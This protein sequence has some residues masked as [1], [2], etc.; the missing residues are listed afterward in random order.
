MMAKQFRIGH[1][2][3]TWG[4]R[5]D[6]LEGAVRD[7]AELGYQGFET[8]GETIVDYNRQDP[9]GFGALLKKYGIPLASIY[10]PVW[11]RE[12]EQAQESIEQVVSWSQLARDLGASTVV[13]Q[14]GKRQPQPYKNYPFLVG[15]FDEIGRRLADMG[16][17]T[18]VHP[19]T[20][21]L[22]ETR[23]EIDAVLSAVDP[24]FVGF[25]PDTGQIVKGGSDVMPVLEDYGSL[26]RHVHLKDYI[27]G[28]VQYDQAGKEIDATG[29][30]GYLPLGMGVL[31]FS[32]VFDLMERLNF[33]GW[34]MVELDATGS[35]PRPPREAARIS[36]DFLHNT[37]NQQFSQQQD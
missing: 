14:G 5:L 6:Q 34:V 36:R 19:H 12:P 35:F 30:S 29:Y 33:D 11:A 22:I 13:I 21:T 17:A 28:P 3:I 24:R 20:G 9:A 1:T 26:I 27:G 4:Y 10:C 15:V 32:Q 16:L 25:A 31:D 7:T 23:E 18:A 37:L 8:F 2:G